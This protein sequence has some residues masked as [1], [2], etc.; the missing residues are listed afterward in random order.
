VRPA[1]VGTF[2]ARGVN[3]ELLYVLAPGPQGAADPLRSV[4]PLDADS[5]AARVTFIDGRVYQVRFG[6]GKADAKQIR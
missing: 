1:P 3:R 4:E 5:R 2:S 6:T